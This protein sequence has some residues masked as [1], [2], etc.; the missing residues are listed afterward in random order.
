MTTLMSDQFEEKN[1][2]DIEAPTGHSSKRRGPDDEDEDQGGE[3]GLRK[4][5][6]SA[7]GPGKHPEDTKGE[8]IADK[9]QRVKDKKETKASNNG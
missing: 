8:V 9:H 2:N 7:P 5:K 6:A 4:P 3:T 1:T